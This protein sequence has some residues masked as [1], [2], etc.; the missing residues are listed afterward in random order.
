M[1]VHLHAAKEQAF[2]ICSCL[3]HSPPKGIKLLNRYQRVAC[4]LSKDFVY[5]SLLSVDKVNLQKQ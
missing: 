4:L 5:Y 1:Y 3:P 2:S